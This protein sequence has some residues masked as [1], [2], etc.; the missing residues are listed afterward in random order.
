MLMNEYTKLNKDPYRIFDLSWA[1]WVFD[2]YILILF[3]FLKTQL[4]TSL[5]LSAEILSLCHNLLELDNTISDLIFLFMFLIGFG[6]G[7]S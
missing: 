6:T 2:F 4:Q 7:F 5:N 3:T 1:G